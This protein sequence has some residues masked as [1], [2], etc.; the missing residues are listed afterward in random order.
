MEVKEQKFDYKKNIEET[1]FEKLYGQGGSFLVSPLSRS[2]MFSKEMFSEDQKMFADAAYEYATTRMKPLKDKLST[3]NEELTLE[4]F[5]ELGEMGFLGVDM[6]E[7][8]GGSNLDKTTAAIVVDYLAFSECGSIMVTLGAHSGIGALPIVW[9]G[10]DAQKEKYLPKI[11]SGEWLACFALTEPNAGSDAMNGESTAYLND[12]KTHYILNGQKIWITN[13]SWA[14]SCIAF[15]KV[16]GKMTAFIV[17]KDCEGWVIG[18]EEK[19]MGIK[20]SSTVTMYFENCKVPVENL[21]GSVGEGGHIAL[22][23]LYAGR[24]KLGF[25]SSAGSM[26]S[27]NGSYNFAK[28][29]KQF[30]RS[31]LNFDMIKNKFANMIV[32]TWESDTINYATTGSIDESISKLDPNDKDYY[33]KVQKITEDHAIEASVSKVVGSEA[34]AYCADEGVQ[35]FGGSG[36]CEEY[37]AAGVYRDERINRI[38]EGTNEINRLII[39]GTVLKKAIL[40]ELPIRDALILRSE[41]M[42]DSN[43]FDNEV[44]KEAD[45]IEFCK[46]TGLFVLDNLI[47]IYGQDFKN[48]QWLIEPFADIVCSI[49][50]MHNCFLRYNQLEHG[51]HKNNTL[52]VLKLSV[53]QHFNKLISRVKSINSHICNH[54][55]FDSDS[56]KYDFCNVTNSKELNYLPNEIN[57]KKEIIEEFYKQ[58]KYYLNI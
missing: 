3:L 36:F 14:K 19:K 55:I 48:K 40:E 27:I 15:A 28:E 43:T 23:C 31:I 45:V 20:G 33:V 11:A 42:Y 52:P 41:N 26:S 10:T 25:S 6:P 32:R 21:L 4:I 7:K 37:P 46:S 34:L 12:E 16:S 17:D 18:A 38:F 22:N 9:Y 1:N 58:E 30:S 47:N 39:S 50:I 13:G 8:Y 51:N 2:K 56:E 54:M 44:S 53:S 5:K 35:I 24:W 57:L 49:A 29:R